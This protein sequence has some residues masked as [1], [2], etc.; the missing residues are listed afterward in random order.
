LRCT[1][2]FISINPRI[3]IEMDL[4]N[5]IWATLQGGYKIPYN[6]SRPLKQLRDVTRQED[7][8]VIFKELWDNLYHQGDVGTAS[9]LAVPQLVSICITKKSLDWNFIGLC[10]LIENSRLREHNPE[11]PAAYQDYYFD[12]LTQFERYLL[13]N[14]KSITDQTALRLTLA[15]FATLNGQPGLGRAIEML[16]EDMLPEFLEQQ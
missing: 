3:L 16:D 7:S 13:L 5:K 11:L 6:P 2:T 10:V 9:Y 1:E 12:S 4:D 15:L 8:E 14:F